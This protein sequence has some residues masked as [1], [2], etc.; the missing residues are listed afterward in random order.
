MAGGRGI[1]D[2]S[3]GERNSCSEIRLPSVVD[4]LLLAPRIWLL[5]GGAVGI[6]WGQGNLV[7]AGQC[8][9][10]TSEYVSR[11][12]ITMLGD[13]LGTPQT[14]MVENRNYCKCYGFIMKFLVIPSK[15]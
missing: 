6:K 2:Q 7:V 14:S 9:I 12:D 11:S 4:L 5:F 13:A 15:A 3:R 8:P 10:L 1:K